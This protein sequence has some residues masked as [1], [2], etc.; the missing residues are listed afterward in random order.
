MASPYSLDL[1]QKILQA[2]E[3][4]MGSQREIAEFFGVSLSFVEKLLQRARH[5]GDATAKK[6]GRSPST[7]LDDTAQAH[8]RLLVERQPDITLAELADHVD[9]LTGVRVRPATLCR[10]LQRLRMPLK[11]D[12]PCM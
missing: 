8:V 2:H 9:Q 11:K 12:R 10:L 4:G 1:R 7:R 6:Q 3:R 5:T